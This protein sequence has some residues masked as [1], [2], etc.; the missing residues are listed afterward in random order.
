MEVP[1]SMRSD[2]AAWNDGKGIDLE[3]WVGC[4]GSFS[5]A[6]GYASIFWPEFVE[7]E[8]YVLRKN[9][10]EESLREFEKMNGPDRAATES[11]MNHLHIVDIQHLGCADISRDKLQT[12]GN[13]LK[14]IYLMKLCCE[15]PERNFSVEFYIPEDQE[16]LIDY[17]ISFWTQRDTTA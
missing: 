13:V 16:L 6:V 2:L 14:E 4:M 7:F 9:F 11:V 8:G 5:L 10:R 1:E 15:F 12:L 17:Q 3:T